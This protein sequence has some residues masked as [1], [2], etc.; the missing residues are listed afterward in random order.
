MHATLTHAVG[1]AEL[2]QELRPLW[3]AL[4]RHHARLAPDLAA[5]LASFTFER[6]VSLLEGRAALRVDLLRDPQGA[7]AAYAFGSVDVHGRGDLESIYVSPEHRGQGH[8][9]ALVQQ[10]IAWM[11]A[12]GAKPIRVTVAAG[13]EQALPFYGEQGFRNR[14]T[15]LW[16]EQERDSE[17]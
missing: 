1:G 6:R 2:L 12:R 16:L 5:H 4:N 3:E 9:R 14:A 7:P 10:Q 17:A 13:N 8:G 15:V 11:R